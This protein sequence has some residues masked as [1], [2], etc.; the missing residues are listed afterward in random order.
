MGR[1][2]VLIVEDSLTVRKRLREAIEED[3]AFEVVG[4]AADGLAAVEKC[5][6]LRPDVVSLDM[7][8]PGINGVDVA[9]RVMA[10]CATPILVVSASVNRG[11][12]LNTFDALQ[13]GAVEVYDKSQMGSNP[14]WSA[15]LRA[16]LRQVSRIPVISRAWYG[17]GGM[18][19]RAAAARDAASGTAR[20]EPARSA[21]A[22]LDTPLRL[23]A[24]GASTG[25]PAA[26]AR[27]L[28][29]LPPTFPVPI[30][31][32]LHVAPLFGGMLVE[33]L[34]QQTPLKV[35]MAT[36]GMAIPTPGAPATVFVAP[37]ERHM[38]VE[39]GRLQLTADPEVHCC[40]PSIDVLFS[41]IAR[42]CGSNVLGCVLTGMGCDGAAGLL[43]MRRSGART[44]VQDEASSVVFGM[45][46]EAIALGAA[47]FV[48]SPEEIAH[49]LCQYA[50]ARTR[51]SQSS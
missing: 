42:E 15:D 28:G 9:R 22:A 40:R 45:P 17:E 31:L 43:A 48:L 16:L 38:I 27:I 4:E 44:L 5:R 23:V 32:V 33:W 1:I 26:V 20:V 24:I 19:K 12:A 3:S 46:R 7:E 14:G 47:E 29:A 41:S 18:L 10:D 37:P 21:D 36:E 13:A 35:T 34:G 11:E 30:L 6:T 51:R 8:L 39:A 25:G 50:V 49:A 2:R